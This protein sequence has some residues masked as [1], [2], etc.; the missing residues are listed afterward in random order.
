M[1]VDLVT[2]HHEGAGSPSD[3]A[4]GAGG[5]YTY[6][7]GASRF[8]WL[9]SVAT[10]YA[11]LHFNHVSLDIC[12][13]GDRDVS[14]VTDAD[15]ALIHGA[16][17]DAHAR[18]EVTDAPKVQAHRDNNNK[19]YFN[20]ALFSTVCPG[21]LAMA[22][23]ADIV[24]ACRVAPAPP[25][26]DWAALARIQA[27][28]DRR[29]TVPLHYGQRG[30]AVTILNDLLVQHGLLT[31]SG[32]AFGDATAHALGSFKKQAHLRNQD[33]HVCDHECAVALFH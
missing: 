26:I 2:I 3:I 10:S 24:A 18:G 29:V 7:I 28:V 17:M 33:T 21:N 19:Y 15:I 30:P 16:F 4:R 23:W 5:G 22:R 11:T 12:L 20:G 8:E 32:E 27:W 31:K 1:P 13:S 14:P 25:V 9:R 6:W